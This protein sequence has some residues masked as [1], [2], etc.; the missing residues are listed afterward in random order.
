MGNK[1]KEPLL[2]ADQKEKPVTVSVTKLFRFATGWDWFLMSLGT[3][4]AVANGVGLPLMVSDLFIGCVGVV[5]CTLRHTQ[6]TSD[7]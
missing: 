4:G 6:T 7:L 5:S 2:P 1:P 3:L